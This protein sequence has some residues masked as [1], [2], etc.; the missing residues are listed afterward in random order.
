MKKTRILSEPE[1]QLQKQSSC[2]LFYQTTIPNYSGERIESIWRVQRTG[3]P[4]EL[5]SGSQQYP[6]IVEPNYQT[7]DQRLQL[8][9][10]K[11]RS[12]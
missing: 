6:R 2:L 4:S 10:A 3:L 11:R 5:L 1:K 8:D 7:V 9:N 12:C